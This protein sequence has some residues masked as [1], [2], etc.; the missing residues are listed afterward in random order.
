MFHAIV[1]VF[2]SLVT[3]LATLCG[4]V[5]A[6]MPASCGGEPAF[7]REGGGADPWYCLQDGRY[8]YCYSVGNGAAVKSADALEDVYDAEGRVV[9]RAPEGT[10]FSCD[11][12]A[13]ELH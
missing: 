1:A 10:A 7:I 2:V 12:W 9:Y 4:T 8:Y 6:Q 13:P 3:C 5:N 11:W